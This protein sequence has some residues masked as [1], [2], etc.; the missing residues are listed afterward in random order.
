[1]NHSRA[2]SDLQT[3][4]ELYVHLYMQVQGVVC[5][6]MHVCV[7]VLAYLLPPLNALW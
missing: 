2:S 5:V 3:I 1:M 6:C 7:Y 4:E